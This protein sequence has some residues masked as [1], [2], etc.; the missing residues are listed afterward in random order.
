MTSYQ[1]QALDR[2]LEVFLGR[3]GL[4]RR[5]STASCAGRRGPVFCPALTQSRS[6]FIVW[7]GGCE[8]SS[9]VGVG[10]EG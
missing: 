8:V 10:K 6:E 4:I 3:Y 5:D 2:I 9:R 1:V 7:V